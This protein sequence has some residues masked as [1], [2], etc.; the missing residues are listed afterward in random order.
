LFDRITTDE[1][2]EQRIPYPFERLIA[3]IEAAAGCSMPKPCTRAVLVPLGRSLQRA[4][5]SPDFFAHPRAV[6][7]VTEEGGGRL[8]RDRLYL[9]F[10]E[11]AGVIE[12]ISYNE[13]QGR[14]EFQIVSDYGEGQ[15]ARVTYARRSLCIACHQSQGPVFSQPL[16]LET[17]ANPQI[18][19]ALRAVRSS[20][21]SVPAVVASDVSQAIDDSTDRSNRMLLTQRLWRSGCGELDAG[22]AC[23]R[24]VIK[25]ALQLALTGARD[26]DADALKI[27]VVARLDARA[28][29][30][31]PAGLALASGDLPNRNPFDL[32][33]GSAGRALVDIETRFDPLVPRMPAEIIPADGSQLADELVRGVAGFIGSPVRDRIA[34]SLSNRDERRA[35]QVSCHAAEAANGF[36]C[37]SPDGATYVRGEASA[38]SGQLSEIRVAGGR[39]LRHLDLERVSAKASSGE[40][41]I[42]DRGRDIRLPT[43]QSLLRLDMS[44]ATNAPALLWIGERF[45]IDEALSETPVAILSAELFEQIS[46]R[47]EGRVPKSRPDE[48]RNVRLDESLR[49]DDAD[50]L[51]FAFDA[52]CGGCHRTSQTSPPNFLFGNRARVQASLRSCAPRIYVRIGMR[53]LDSSRREKSPM[54]PETASLT[55]RSD[56][57]EEG[58]SLTELRRSVESMLKDEYGRV[59]S[60][61]ELMSGGYESLRTCLPP[62]A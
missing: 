41:R 56:V 60:V 13:A 61:A 28:K 43:G 29:S 55:H 44:R 34:A 59:P 36:E 10:Q 11:R 14:F 40:L 30:M 35:V 3:R 26:Y 42:H 47:L 2:G 24:A 8:L 32:I 57:T 27:N 19:N 52:P 33:Q 4:A 16:W 49:G 37:A 38:R 21:H 17:N 6:V 9:G 31:W 12:V 7:A 50:P 20:F 22:D 51:S 5:A 18:A 62:Q 1:R 15:S 46:D 23:R 48:P 25:A 45:D 58:A 53:Q 39:P 54:P